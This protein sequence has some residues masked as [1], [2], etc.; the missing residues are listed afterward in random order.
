MR[1]IR[2]GGRE[3]GT[4]A[5]AMGEVTKGLADTYQITYIVVDIGAQTT[6]EHLIC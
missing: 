5:G 1:R 2:A 6:A 4:V 3:A